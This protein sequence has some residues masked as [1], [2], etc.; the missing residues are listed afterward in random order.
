MLTLVFPGQGSQYI[1]MGKDFFDNFSV[2][3]Q[4][5][6]EVDESL[7]FSLS[8]IMWEGTLEELTL[9]EN[10]QPAIMTTSIAI[11]KAIEKEGF[12]VKK[13]TFVA[14]HSLGEYTA[15]CASGAIKLSDTANLLKMRGLFMQKS[16]PVGTGAM[17]AI[18]GL[19]LENTKSLISEVNNL[20]VCEIANDNEPN[21]VVISGDKIAIEHACKVAKSFGAK[22]ALLLP[23]SAP[24]HC[25]LMTPAR[26]KM[27]DFLS[28]VVINTPF[29]PL[30][31][32][33]IAKPIKDIKEI[34]EN[35]I[36]QITGRV[37]WRESILFMSNYG[38]NKAYEIGPGKVLSNLVKRIDG[39][40]DTISIS[41]AEDLIKLKD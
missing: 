34:R 40:I 13:S 12:D 28:E 35:L 19:D 2:S 5:F 17:A 1:G 21:Q 26:N 6:E 30:I 24:F 41:K 32:N 8:K 25:S 27:V 29:V 39:K 33:V 15:L 16:V 18:L 20:G 23:V 10:A 3:K 7:G 31:S 22:R 38:I 37:R 11:L 9:T 14:G 36:K 4:V